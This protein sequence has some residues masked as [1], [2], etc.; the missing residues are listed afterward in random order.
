MSPE[1]PE[2]SEPAEPTE[3]TEPAEPLTAPQPTPAG[4]VSEAAAPTPAAATAVPGSPLEDD[5]SEEPEDTR[6]ARLTSGERQRQS[7]ALAELAKALVAMTSSQ[8]AEVALPDEVREEV[9]V[10]RGLGRAARM[11]QLKRIAQLLRAHDVDEISAKAQDAGHKQR[12]R[13]ARERVYEAWRERLVAEGDRA[14]TEFVDE[15]PMADPQRLRQ[16]LRQAR[17]D[18]GSGKSKQGMRALLQLVR[19]TFESEASVAPWA[20]AE[21][22]PGVED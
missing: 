21:S 1:P 20:V 4:D 5:A 14:L 7:A 11:R 22:E 13:A 15:H 2:R 17:R 3:P 10:C 6:P 12:R 16:L 9:L 18:P 8:L 19:Q